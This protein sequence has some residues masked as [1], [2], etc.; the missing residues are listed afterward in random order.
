MSTE[1]KI[2]LLLLSCLMLGGLG[3]SALLVSQAQKRRERIDSRFQAVVTPHVRA[4]RLEVS[5][6]VRAQKPRDQSLVG[7]A[8]R[9]FNFSSVNPDRYPLPWWLVVCVAT[10]IGF[11]IRIPA[12]DFIGSAS[13][14]AIPASTLFLSRQF[15]GWFDGRRREKMLAQ[16]PDAL[17]MIVRSVRVGIP[18]QEAIR[19]V[20]REAQ[21]PTGA[22]F[23]R[24]VDQVSVGV[25]MEDAMNDMATR[26]GLPEYRFFATGLS[27]QNQT[28]GAL[29][30]TLENLADLIR[31]R[32]ML[33]AKGRALTS[34]A[35]AGAAVLTVMPFLTGG[36]LY[37]LNPTYISLLFTDPTGH[38]LL[39][40]AIVSL[41]LGLIVIR[42]IIRSALAA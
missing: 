26:A 27:L 22:E 40:S 20:A 31:K 18:V 28:G 1:I 2:A 37:L 3:L 12:S 41:C 21:N 6:F 32:V 8:A 29:S 25:A 35:K 16:F 9:V 39:G 17:T 10:V 33:K 24:L 30:E 15:F 14:I 7:I 38:K 23:A 4:Q 19:M 5:A 34:E 11:G 42:S 13:I 36:G